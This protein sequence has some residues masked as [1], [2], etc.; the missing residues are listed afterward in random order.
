M[1]TRSLPRGT[2]GGSR[3]R[4]PVVRSFNVGGGRQLV[5]AGR[6]VF[7]V[8][9]K[10]LNQHEEG[11]LK[12]RL[13]ADL[14]LAGAHAICWRWCRVQCSQLQLKHAVAAPASKQAARS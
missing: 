2:T 12:P 14:L 1:R 6:R 4:S 13:R 8:S 10:W 9:E 5:T 7:S 11:R 3:V